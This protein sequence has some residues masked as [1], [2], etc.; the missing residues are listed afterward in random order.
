MA[1]TKKIIVNLPDSL[2]KEVDDLVSVE[3]NNRS[4]LIK[5][6]MELY[7]REQRRLQVKEDMKQGYLEM[8]QIN[9]SLSEMGLAEDIRELYAYETNLTGSGE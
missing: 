1:D 6:A 4:D 2:L 9:I 7:V 8:S 3:E 5:E